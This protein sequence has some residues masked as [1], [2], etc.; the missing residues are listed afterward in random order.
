MSEPSVIVSIAGRTGHIL[1]NRPRQLNALDLEM[2]RAVAAALES[3]RRDPAIHAVVIEGAGERAFCAGG[4]IRAVRDAAVEGDVVAI[5]AF[6][7][8]EY[9]LN[10][11]IAGFP[12]PY[13]ALIDGFCMGGGIGVSVHGRIRVTTEAGQFAMPET[14]I[15]LFPDVGA[16][17]VLPRLPGR[18]GMYLGLTGAR[19]VGADAVHAGIATHFV[20]RDALPELR[21]DLALDGVAAV[22]AHA[23][24][25]PVFT[26]APHR[27]SI[28]RCFGQDS[29]AG[30]RAALAAEAS[31][32]AADTLAV[33]D[34]MSP[35]SLRWSHALIRAGERRELAA[36][37]AAELALTRTVT[38]HPDFAEGVRA[39]VVDKDRAPNW[40]PE[41]DD[42]TLAAMLGD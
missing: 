27:P 36:S 21:A 11:A 41:I 33:L 26:L 38:R 35:S 17:F 6:F 3:W 18:I 40:A 39:M 12:K 29:V 1:L 15:G 34:R 32:W 5:E 37:L 30:I 14:A 22:A 9:A 7:A 19:L 28:D 16:S 8:E 23:R 31:P 24:K 25:L 10:A 2:I 4:D 13:V 42:A 20:P